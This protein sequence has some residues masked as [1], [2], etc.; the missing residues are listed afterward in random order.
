MIIHL[1]AVPLEVGVLSPASSRPPIEG[2]RPDWGF[3]ARHTAATVNG[4]YRRTLPYFM[5]RFKKSA[6]ESDTRL[7]S[8]VIFYTAGSCCLLAC[9]SCHSFE[10]HLSRKAVRCD[11]PSWSRVCTPALPLIVFL[12][13]YLRRV[14]PSLTVFTLLGY[15]LPDIS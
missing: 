12:A 1:Q 11:R 3:Y 8:V 4:I 13:S 6:H 5:M 2:Q 7:F 14:L 9:A 15:F 10:P